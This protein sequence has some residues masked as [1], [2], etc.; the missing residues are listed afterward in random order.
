LHPRIRD[1][2]A[3]QEKFS[4]QEGCHGDNDFIVIAIPKTVNFWQMYLCNIYGQKELTTEEGGK[5]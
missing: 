5:Q 4:E 3:L 1:I 2:R